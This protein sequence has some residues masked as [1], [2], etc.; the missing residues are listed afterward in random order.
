MP[1][2]QK[3]AVQSYYQQHAPPY[4]ANR[5]NNSQTVRGYPDVS[6]NGARYVV[7]LDGSYVQLYG[8]SASAPVVASIVTLLNEKRVAA[9]KSTLGFLNPVFYA[10]PGMFNDIVTGGN[11]GCG[12]AGFTAVKG[13]DPGRFFEFSF[14]WVR[15][16]M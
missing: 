9:G 16:E 15:S 12:T 2:Y 6:A 4:G 10:N 5:Y 1:Q 8:T 7:A 11:Q 3:A 13:W 14:S